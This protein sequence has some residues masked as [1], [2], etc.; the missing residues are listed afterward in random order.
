MTTA[1]CQHITTPNLANE[2]PSELSDRPD[3]LDERAGLAV[4]QSRPPT[5]TRNQLQ[6]L[7]DPASAPRS[8][9]GR[10]CRSWITLQALLEAGG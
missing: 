8:S 9:F 6:I 7:G 5:Y 1:L 3:Q 4:G 2:A 10:V